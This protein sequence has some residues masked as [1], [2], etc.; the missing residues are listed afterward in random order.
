MRRMKADLLA[1]RLFGKRLQDTLMRKITP[2]IATV[3]IFPTKIRYYGPAFLRPMYQVFTMLWQGCEDLSFEWARVQ[4]T[5][6]QSEDGG[7]EGEFSRQKKF[8]R[9]SRKRYLDCIADRRRGSPSVTVWLRLQRAYVEAPTGTP[10]LKVFQLSY[11]RE[12]VASLFF[13]NW[14]YKYA[15][16][17]FIVAICLCHL[18]G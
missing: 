7:G 17:L 18:G 12:Q 6:P 14:T 11:F 8:I 9:A 2:Q 10:W 1:L 13:Y 15:K 5:E 16:A 4:H 3:Y